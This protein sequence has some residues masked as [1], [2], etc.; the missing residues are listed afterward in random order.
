MVDSL[1]QDSDVTMLFDPLMVRGLRADWCV[2][3]GRVQEGARAGS[4]VACVCVCVVCVCVCYVLYCV[5]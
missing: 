2:H 1:L 5:L 4:G 3:R